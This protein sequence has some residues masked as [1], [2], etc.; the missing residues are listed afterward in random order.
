MSIIKAGNI[1]KGSYILYR[2]APHYVSYVKFVSP[3]KGSAFSRVKMRDM[4][5]GA[6]VEFT[7]KSHDNVEELDVSSKE[8]QFLYKADDEVIFM[9]PVS[10]EQIPVPAKLLE[11][12]VEMLTADIKVYVLFYEEKALGVSLPPK[13]KLKVA[14]ADNAVTGDRQT[15]GKKPVIMETGLVVQAPLFIKEGDVLSIDTTTGDYVSRVN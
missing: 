2:N 1:K 14:K 7:F 11:G 6:N 12:Q 13:V 8:M 9:D 4:R 10:Y 15:A 5:S 3:G